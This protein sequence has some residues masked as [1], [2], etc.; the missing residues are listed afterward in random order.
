MWQ[1]GLCQR[2]H[3]AQEIIIEHGCKAGRTTAKR[4]N[5]KGAHD[6]YL[7]R[8]AE[9]AKAERAKRLPTSAPLLEK[10]EP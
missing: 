5:S 6:I 1:V 3:T 10:P 9:I 8:V 4:H 7:Q 2:P